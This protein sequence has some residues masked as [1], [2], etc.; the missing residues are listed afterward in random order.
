VH[1]SFKQPKVWVVCVHGFLV[2][3]IY[4]LL[5]GPQRTQKKYFNKNDKNNIF[6][7]LSFRE[8]E[9]YCDGKLPKMPIDSRVCWVNYGLMD[10]SHP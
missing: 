4:H 6:G 3:K 2:I 7:V 10:E 9:L 8:S 1:I 5:G